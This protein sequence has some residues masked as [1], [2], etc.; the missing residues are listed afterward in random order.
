M[1]RTAGCDI[2][3]GRR[4][5][6]SLGSIPTEMSQFSCPLGVP[7]RSILGAEFLLCHEYLRSTMHPT[8]VGR[9]FCSS[10]LQHFNDIA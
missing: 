7:Q 5:C 2:G 9:E 6:I 3:L 4:L 8:E 1:Y 10:F